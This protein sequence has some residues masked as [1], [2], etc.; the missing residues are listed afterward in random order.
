MTVLSSNKRYAGLENYDIKSCAE[1]VK[2][3]FG[4]VDI[5]RDYSYGGFYCIDDDCTFMC[6]MCSDAQA[7]ACHGMRANGDF[8]LR[9][10]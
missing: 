4:K 3:D 10:R 1:Q 5:V 9:A 6:L 2:K 7:L 8:P